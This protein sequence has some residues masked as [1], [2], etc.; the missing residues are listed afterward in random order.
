MNESQPQRR[1]FYP[2]PAW[3]VF[4][5]LATTGLLFLSERW[6]WFPFNEHKGYTVLIAV[7]G[8]GVV[9]ATMLLWWLVALVT[10]WHFQF[11]IR[12]LLVLTVAVAMPFSWLAEEMKKANEQKAAVAAIEKLDGNV[13]YC[14]EDGKDVMELANAQPPGPVWLRNLLG[15]AFFTKVVRAIFYTDTNV[16]DEGLANIARLPQLQDA[17]IESTQVTDAGLAHL[18]RLTELQRVSLDNTQVTDEGL[19]QLAGL[20]ELRELWLDSTRVT[21]AGLAHLAKLTRLERLLLFDTQVAD[22][23]LAHL[24]GLQQLRELTLAQTQ[25]TDAGLAHIARLTRLKDLSLD[26]T[27]ITDAGLSHLAGLTQLQDLGLGGTKVTKAGVRK[28]ERALPRC[29]IRH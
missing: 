5:S 17:K 14:W 21:D 18:A 6:R 19:A 23:G 25:V 10:R 16:T 27:K 8:V 7:A 4:G 11:G 26:D 29:H 28:L 12:T 9:L 3:L 13:T 24:A 15:D 2:T 20:T 22:A 1:W